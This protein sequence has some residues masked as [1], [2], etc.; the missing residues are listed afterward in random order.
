[1][2]V[3]F[4]YLLFVKMR[5]DKNIVQKK[6]HNHRLTS[7]LEVIILIEVG[8]HSQILIEYPVYLVPKNKFKGS[9]KTYIENI[10]RIYRRM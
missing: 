1:M 4:E 6:I 2:H 5:Q 9:T 10:L 7:V 3:N 8:N